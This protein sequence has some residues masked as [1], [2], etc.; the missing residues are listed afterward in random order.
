MFHVIMYNYSLVMWRRK[1]EKRDARPQSGE[2]RRAAVA[3]PC[4][5]LERGRPGGAQA[6]ESFTLKKNS[7]YSNL[8]D[9]EK[10][11]PVYDEIPDFI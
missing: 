10:P 7:S 11:P 1:K 2:P 9:Y 4:N 3:G 6:E 8:A 5:D